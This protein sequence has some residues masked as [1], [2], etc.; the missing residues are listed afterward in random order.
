MNLEGGV[1]STLS[2]LTKAPT[3]LWCTITVETEAW[4]ICSQ[5]KATEVE[6][7]EKIIPGGKKTC[8]LSINNNEESVIYESYLEA[9]CYTEV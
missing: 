1:H 7:V 9:H 4:F 5:I 3:P 2:T 6:R 8:K